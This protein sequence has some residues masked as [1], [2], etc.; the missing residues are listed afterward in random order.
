M[1]KTY[2]PRYCDAFSIVIVSHSGQ[3][4]RLYCPFRVKHLGLLPDYKTGASL[5]VDEVSSTD[6]DELIYVILGTQY[7]YSHFALEA[8]F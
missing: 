1:G 7:L 6:K 3:I 4:N 2:Q 8:R 5:W